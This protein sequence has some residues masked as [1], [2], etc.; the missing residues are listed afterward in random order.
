MRNLRILFS[1]GIACALVQPS[2]CGAAENFLARL[3]R[4]Y[5][6]VRWD[7]S[8]VVTADFNGDKISDRAGIGY[9]GGQVIVSIS[10]G[11]NKNHGKAQLLSFGVGAGIKDAVCEVPATLKV[12]PLECN[13]E[14]SLLPG[15]KRLSAAKG[16]SLSGGEC[17]S[18]HLYWNHLTKQMEWW[19][20]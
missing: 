15:C 13:A 1:L 14:D 19:R 6:E 7:T 18:I 4:S 3:S 11:H 9:K 5:P 17:D 16:L 8:S 10:M 20:P 2:L 12:E